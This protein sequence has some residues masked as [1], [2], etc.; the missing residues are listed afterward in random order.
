MKSDFV[1]FMNTAPLDL[2]PHQA[3][4]RLRFLLEAEE[5]LNRKGITDTTPEE[6]WERHQAQNNGG[7]S[8][9]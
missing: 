5:Y 1:R 2:T 9:E 6:L 8:A 4:E 7:L 3:D